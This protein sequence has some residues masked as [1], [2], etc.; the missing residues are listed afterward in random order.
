[1]R[2]IKIFMTIILC[3]CINMG[4]LIQA[5]AISGLLIAIGTLVMKEGFPYAKDYWYRSEIE[6]K[7][8]LKQ[9]LNSHSYQSAVACGC[10]ENFMDDCHIYA[11]YLKKTVEYNK[12]GCENIG[13]E[14]QQKN[15]EESKEN[16]TNNQTAQSF[17]ETLSDEEKEKVRKI[18]KNLV[19][20]YC[21]PVDYEKEFTCLRAAINAKY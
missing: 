9:Y 4:C 3:V 6:D 20:T 2:K 12:A 16:S 14:N 17:F 21:N 19:T 8:I 10:N 5:E 11:E 1:M 15:Q 13:I 7:R 18:Q